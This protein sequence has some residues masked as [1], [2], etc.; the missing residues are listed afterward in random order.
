MLRKIQCN[1]RWIIILYED[2]KKNFKDSST[3]DIKNSIEESIKEQDEITLPGLG[4]L[5]E[6]LWQN[7][8]NHEEILEC[9]KKGL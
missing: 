8:N 3:D 7:S 5:F 9:I 6:I 2:I 1:L 4:V